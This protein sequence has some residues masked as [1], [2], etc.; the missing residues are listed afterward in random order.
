MYR[1]SIFIN[2]S[3]RLQQANVR[4]RNEVSD[5]FTVSNGVKQGS[6]VSAVLY[7]C[8]YTNGLFENLKRQNIGCCTKQGIRE[9]TM[10]D[11]NINVF[12][13]KILPRT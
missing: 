9:R 6:V 7:Y 4:W 8:V 5:F 10:N 3:Y 2:I 12:L 13:F 1:G 11:L